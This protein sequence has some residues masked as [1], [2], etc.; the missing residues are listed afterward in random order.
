M[1][2]FLQW[3]DSQQYL[4]EQR[5]EI[6]VGIFQ[7]RRQSEDSLKTYIN[8]QQLSPH[9]PAQLPL[10]PLTEERQSIQEPD[11]ASCNTGKRTILSCIW[12]KAATYE[13]GTYGTCHNIKV[14]RVPKDC[15]FI[16]DSLRRSSNKVRL[17]CTHS[18]CTVRILLSFHVTTQLFQFELST[19]VTN[20]TAS[21]QE[22]RA[23][24]Q[25]QLSHLCW[26]AVR[27]LC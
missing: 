11:S 6:Q 17:R 12:K 23:Q 26:A 8:S 25:I 10:F 27:R 24:S 21:H 1:P 13:T 15:S 14:D 4:G 2:F 20:R 19:A 22:Q 16:M 5:I 3:S 9:H 18:L 7:L